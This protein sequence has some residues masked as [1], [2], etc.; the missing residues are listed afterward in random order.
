[1]MLEEILSLL[2]Q[3]Q[4]EEGDSGTDDVVLELNWDSLESSAQTMAALLSLFALAPIPWSLVS[5]AAAA[6]SLDF[7]LV[8]N[9]DILVEKYLLQKLDDNTYQLHERIREFLSIKRE[10]LADIEKLKRGV[11][12]AIVAIAKDIP[13]TLIKSDIL[14][15]TPT[16]PH[17]VEVATNQKEYLNDEDLIWPFVGLAR[18]YKGQ[19]A[20]EKALTWYQQCLST[21][22]DRLGEE[23][24]DVAT[25]LNNLALLYY[26]QG[27]YEEAEPLYLQSLDLRKHL[28]G[29]EYPDVAKPFTL[30]I[31]ENKFPDC[32]TMDLKVKPVSTGI[33]S[34]RKR[35]Q[36]KLYLTIQFNEQWVQMPLGRVRFGLKG[37]ELRLR[38]KNGKIPLEARNLS[39]SFDP[40]V[41]K[42]RRQ[43]ESQEN[44]SK[45]EASWDK[46]PPGVKANHGHKNTGGTTDGFQFIDPEITTTGPEETPAWVFEVKTGQPVFKGLLNEVELGTIDVMAKPCYIEATFEVFKPDVYLTGS[47]GLWSP[48][49]SSKQREVLDRKIALLILE[50]QLKPYLS[51]VVLKVSRCTKLIT[52]FSKIKALQCKGYRD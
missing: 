16:I 1:M 14:A 32:V 47:E 35:K 9:R 10:Q 43:Q 33:F 50:H 30:L 41:E 11:C 45:V 52:H 37:G 38:L 24:P 7:D 18:F 27:R 34:S 44:H 28:L 4:S 31:E 26:T 25:S 3:K 21:V 22:R 15:H 19:G 8:V 40:D 20:Y 12:S 39:G 51:K 48:E 17:L 23:H 29:Q 42:E 36:L 13:E 6:A 5:E 46:N 2:E 49:I